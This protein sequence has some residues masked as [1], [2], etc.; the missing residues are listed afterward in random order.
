[1]SDGLL[2]AED[3]FPAEASS[4]AL[5]RERVRKAADTCGFAP[6]PRED[7]VLAVD[8]ACQN[9]IRHA[10]GGRGGDLVLTIRRQ[11]DTIVVFLRDYAKP[12]DP[13][14]IRPRDLGDLR[15]GGLGTHFINEVMD[16]VTFLPPP[17]G[18]GNL[19]R[20]AKRIE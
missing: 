2:L 8:E 5:I 18:R 10:Y 3:R 17:G 14:T 4:L 13:A 11:E 15:P 16:E 19:L 7:L 20:L 12:V 1:M 6:A 9:V